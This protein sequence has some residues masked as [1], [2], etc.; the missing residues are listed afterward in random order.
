MS[1]K[2]QL[3]L[4]GQLNDVG[5]ATRTNAPNS[6]R[7]GIELQ[8]GYVFS[9]WLN[10]IANLSFSKNKIKDYTAYFN[11]YDADWNELPQ[12]S[13]SYHNSDIAFSP[14]LVGAG[15]L[16]IL[17]CKNVQIS[18]IS[19]YVGDQYL[20]NTQNATRLLKGYYNQDARVIL[21]LRNKIFKEWNIIGQ[22]YNVFNHLYDTNGATYPEYDNG[23]LKNYNYFF[24]M[25]GTNFM[26]GINI[27]L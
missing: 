3:V 10:V 14:K 16:N 12:Q 9:N 20:D 6:Y 15:S 25:A 2:N 17:P 18:L 7:A 1:Y 24:P 21:T 27:K 8:G 13:A 23:V 4:T 19:K 22:V 26:V 11:A 5:S